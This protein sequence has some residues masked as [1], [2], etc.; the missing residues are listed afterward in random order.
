MIASRCVSFS[1]ITRP[2]YPSSS[3]ATTRC[4]SVARASG[5]T[6]D[7]AFVDEHGHV[8]HHADDRDVVGQVLLDERGPDA[9]GE[10]HHEVVGRHVLPI[11]DSS[12]SMSCNDGEHQDVG[13]RHQ[14]ADV[15]SR[16]R[17][18]ALGEPRTRSSRRLVTAISAGSRP[19]SGSSPRRGPRPCG[20]LRGTRPSDLQ[21]RRSR[22]HPLTPRPPCPAPAVPAGV[23]AGPAVLHLRGDTETG[24]G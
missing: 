15:R 23:R 3:S 8:G 22:P 13:R 17:R 6:T 2:T 14:L 12:A 10:A 24:A 1:R 16:A 21:R 18:A 19:P 20:R 11:S 5:A 7:I 4:S 9:R